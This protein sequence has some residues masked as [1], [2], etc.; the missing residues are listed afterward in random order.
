MSHRGFR[1]SLARHA[2]SMR[3]PDPE[4]AFRAAQ[5]AW[6]E[7]GILLINPNTM[8]NERGFT[9]GDREMV[10][11]IGDKLYGKRNGGDK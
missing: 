11:A 10:A 1:S 5:K 8:T 6:R 3:D 2:P 9:W 4:A 7:A